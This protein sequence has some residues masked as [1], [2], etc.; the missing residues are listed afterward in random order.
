MKTVLRLLLNDLKRDWKRPWSTLLFAAMPLVLSTLIALVFG[1]QSGA[2]PM[3]TIQVAV[4]DEDQDLLTRLLRS[5]PAQGDA[6]RRLQLHFVAS[7]Q[8]GLRLLERRKASALVVLPKNLTQNLLKGQTNSIEFY[9][10]P[11]EQVLPKIV[12]EGVSLLALGL[13]GAAGTLGEPLRDFR[14]LIRSNDFPAEAAVSGIASASVQKLRGL[15]TYLFPP[16]VQFETVAA[17]D[18][19][20]L[21]T[22]A[23]AAPTP[24]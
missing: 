15:R 3:P 19:V 24:P 4:L 23:P 2:G 6:A 11:A 17:A 20:P 14:E 12:W 10:N 1:G 5:L 9:E 22:N 7:R 13:S 21:P 16:L 8:E 18:F